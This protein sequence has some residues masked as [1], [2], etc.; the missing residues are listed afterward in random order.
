MID[1]DAAAADEEVDGLEA[2]EAAAAELELEA[3]EEEPPWSSSPE[4]RNRLIGRLELFSVGEV[5]S[6]RAAALSEAE[7]A[8]ALSASL[9]S[10]KAAEA[11][12]DI[13]HIDLSGRQIAAKSVAPDLLCLQSKNGI[14][15]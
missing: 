9:E 6:E 3:T 15:K 14:D 11:A 4:L 12:A 8:A 1:S 5:A 2:A 10:K 13:F 7:P